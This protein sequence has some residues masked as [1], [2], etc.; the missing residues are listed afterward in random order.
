MHKGQAQ[1]AIGAQGQAQVAIGAQ[2]QAQ[3]AIGAQ[4]I[5]AQGQAQVAIGAQGQAQV[6]IGAQG[7][8]QVAQ[9]AMQG[10]PGFRYVCCCIDGVTADSRAIAQATGPLNCTCVRAVS[11]GHRAECPQVAHRVASWECHAMD[12]TDHDQD[13]TLCPELEAELQSHAQVHGLSVA[14]GQVCTVS[15]VRAVSYGSQEHDVI[16]DSGADWSCLPLEYAEYGVKSPDIGLDLS[17]AQG[18]GLAV[19]DFRDVEFL[20][21]TADGD[22]VVW[23]DTC[24]ITNVT[25]PLLCEGKLMRGGWWPSPGGK[26]KAQHHMYIKHLESDLKVPMF[27]KG[28]STCVRA[29]IFRVGGE[30]IAP[31]IRFVTATPAQAMVEAPYGWQMSD[32]GHLFFRGRSSQCTDPSVVAPV[33][34]PCRTTIV[35]PCA[36]G[37]DW[38]VLELSEQ[39]SKLGELTADL[40]H[41][42]CE[43]L[44]ILSTEVE[45]PEEMEF[46]MAHGHVVNWSGKQPGE[47][48]YEP[49]E[50]SV[51]EGLEPEQVH[52]ANEPVPD[53][54][55]ELPP[56][57]SAD[58]VKSV[59]YDGVE[60]SLASTLGAL[61]AACTSTGLSKSGG[62]RR[63]LDRLHCYLEKQKIALQSEVSQ[64]VIEAGQREPKPQQIIKEPSASERALH[65]LTHW[66]YQA[67]CDHC[68]SMRGLQDRHQ[69]V[70]QS[71]DRD[72]PVIS[73][74]ICYTGISDGASISNESSK[75]TVLV[76]HDTSAGSVMGLPLPSKA[77]P[78]LRYA[79]LELTR[80]VQGLGHNTISL[81][82]DNEPA[83]LALQDLI[84]AVRTRLGFK[85][86]VRDAAVE[87]H[88]SNGH[89]EKT[90]DLLRGLSNVFLD[91]ARSKYGIEINADHPLMA[92]SYV[93]ASFILNRF[94]VKGGS[95]AHER[96]TGFRYSGKLASFAE[97]VWG[98]RR[99]KAKGDRKWHR[100]MFLTKSAHNDMCVLMNEQGVWLTVH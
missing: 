10:C 83:T 31:Q 89:A 35:K 21:E 36:D 90:V 97:P 27:F 49:S 81:Q 63:C 15:G 8:V 96:S 82:T 37:H 94:A 86:L 65:E 17:D 53:V 64:A 4:G 18:S 59:L 38:M 9:S 66:P 13:W 76:A 85:T 24:A 69:Q 5:G 51:V 52:A 34:W 78:D 70:K 16:L 62:K 1:V 25:Q 99:G 93:H 84:T 14:A 39:W 61:R 44:T 55:M 87:S 54:D 43:V 95:T 48:V 28:N 98:F 29:Q 40:P 11:E 30:M 50:G 47:A 20:L 45:G 72:T 88:A 56:E 75:L 2:G 60:L 80:F 74:D 77:K 12:I 42:P 67:W 73:F 6:A 92:W 19:K 33:G 41:G 100:A 91:Q 7:Q 68:I 71:S 32:S 58:L 22:Q 23:K 46:G 26:G 79:A 3:V 57:A